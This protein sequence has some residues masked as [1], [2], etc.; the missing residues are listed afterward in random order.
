MENNGQ[1]LPKAFAIQIDYLP[2]QRNNIVEC[3]LLF[4]NQPEE[5][6]SSLFL[7]PF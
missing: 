1:F 2:R 3:Y 4:Q 5:R 7:F 6:E